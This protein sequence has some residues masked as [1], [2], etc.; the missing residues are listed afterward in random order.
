VNRQH[1]P[2]HI[3]IL[4]KFEQGGLAYNLHI[5]EVSYF[6]AEED[7]PPLKLFG[8]ALY[9]REIPD[10]Q[11]VLGL[12]LA[13]ETPKRLDATTLQVGLNG[14]G[15]IPESHLEKHRLVWKI[16][17][18]AEDGRTTKDSKLGFHLFTMFDNSTVEEAKKLAGLIASQT[19]F[20]KQLHSGEYK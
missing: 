15:G 9:A 11:G 14:L 17:E 5:Y 18:S 2:R 3:H 6:L 12:V 10:K 13:L 19:V 1:L 4:H 8:F 20:K 16:A 7:A